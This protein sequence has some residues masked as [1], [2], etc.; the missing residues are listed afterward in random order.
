MM[1]VFTKLNVTVFPYLNQS[2]FMYPTKFEL[3]IFSRC[4]R[5][6]MFTKNIIKVS[7][8]L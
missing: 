4:I 2:N 5:V 7:C 8:A 6:S 3:E 1:V